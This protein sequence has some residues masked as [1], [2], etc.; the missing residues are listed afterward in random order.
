MTEIIRY[1]E[2]E[3][4]TKVETPSGTYI[5]TSEGWAAV[6]GVARSDVSRAI[7]SAARSLTTKVYKQTGQKPSELKIEETPEGYIMKAYVPE[8]P[9]RPSPETYRSTFE[10]GT[11]IQLSTLPSH[12]RQQVETQL[13]K[14]AA[15]GK[16]VTVSVVQAKPVVELPSRSEQT[17]FL[18]PEAALAARSAPVPGLVGFAT[19]V[20]GLTRIEK[21]KAEESIAKERELAEKAPIYAVAL[22]IQRWGMTLPEEWG[23]AVPVLGHAAGFLVG[24][25]ATWLGSV[26]KAPA[27]VGTAIRAK[28]EGEEEVASTA[29]QFAGLSAAEAVVGAIE[30]LGIGKAIG[31][32]AK[33]TAKAASA[34]AT[35]LEPF[36]TRLEPMI[37]PARQ[38]VS[39]VKERVVELTQ[40]RLEIKYAVK[41]GEFPH[42]KLGGLEGIREVELAFTKP[43]LKEGETLYKL[44]YGLEKRGELTYGVF[45]K[46]ESVE[47]MYAVSRQEATPW[48]RLSKAWTEEEGTV[49]KR[50]TLRFDEIIE[51]ETS[52]TFFFAVKGRYGRPISPFKKPVEYM[53]EMKPG[54][55]REGLRV[56]KEFYTRTTSLIGEKE[57][58]PFLF[59]GESK[60]KGKIES[61][62]FDEFVRIGAERANKPLGQVKAEVPESKAIKTQSLEMRETQSART[63]VEQ[64]QTFK[65]VLPKVR[66]IEPRLKT[67]S[68]APLPIIPLARE[69]ATKSMSLIM[70]IELSKTVEFES[71]LPFSAEKPSIKEMTETI[72]KPTETIKTAQFEEPIITPIAPIPIEPVRPL[73]PQIPLPP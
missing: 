39:E 1:Y 44:E 36:T 42:G 14:A 66:E 24:G 18:S 56:G 60:F 19:D 70:P 68:R 43:R 58:L 50:K 52:A 5:Y 26:V 72:A 4:G 47:A 33:G 57:P 21:E 29:T 61:T 16:P 12:I 63:M 20:F 23:K 15:E 34:V 8:Q 62:G 65:Y 67:S 32:A 46:G 7:E 48:A 59:L 9:S 35:R 25:F 31:L 73:V 17:A 27:A 13:A 51:S 28:I 54:V 41:A 64:K 11:G 55:T 10:R 2:P 69:S 3:L 38:T 49:A 40:P 37:A 53:L 30:G 71:I 6:G 22:D 45:P